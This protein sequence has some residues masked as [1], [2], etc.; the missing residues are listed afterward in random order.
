[1]LDDFTARERPASEKESKL[2][3]SFVKKIYQQQVFLLFNW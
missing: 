2:D 3:S 1:M